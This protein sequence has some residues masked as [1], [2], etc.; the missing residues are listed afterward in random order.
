MPL[1]IRRAAWA[2]S[3]NRDDVVKESLGLPGINQVDTLLI[4]SGAIMYPRQLLC[5]VRIV[6]AQQTMLI[7]TREYSSSSFW[8]CR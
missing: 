2:M 4:R 6:V 3:L 1:L 7:R 5:L 8:V